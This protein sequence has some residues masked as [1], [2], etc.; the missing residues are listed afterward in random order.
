MID[1]ALA[2]YNNSLIVAVGQ[3]IETDVAFAIL[4]GPFFGVATVSDSLVHVAS[5]SDGAL[6]RA[7]LT[8]AAV[9]AAS[10]SDRVL[11]SASLTDTL[12]DVADLEVEP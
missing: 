8:D 4:A 12:V 3:I 10:L 2:I 11:W 1:A 7:G 9:D 5:L 6:W